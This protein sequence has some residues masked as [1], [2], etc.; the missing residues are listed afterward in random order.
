MPAR[1]KAN[2]AEDAARCSF[3]WL[4]PVFWAWSAVC[5]S[6][7]GLVCACSAPLTRNLFWTGMPTCK[8]A[9]SRAV[10]KRSTGCAAMCGE[11]KCIP[12]R[13]FVKVELQ[14]MLT[15]CIWVH[16]HPIRALA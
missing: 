3:S 7:L 4:V 11:E 10:R 14:S 5:I 2:V 12:G 13:H 8:A 1:D 6:C 9:T 15:D 16:L